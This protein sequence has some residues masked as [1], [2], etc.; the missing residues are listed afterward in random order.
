MTILISLYTFRQRLDAYH[1]LLE[2]MCEKFPQ[3][4]V[5]IDGRRFTIRYREH[6][7][8]FVPAEPDK[9]AG[10]ECDYFFTNS[11]EVAEYLMYR[12]RC[13]EMDDY[14]DVLDILER[15]ENENKE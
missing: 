7:I 8:I 2:A 13:G 10:R 4:K 6:R 14:M 11:L 1:K 5:R 9:I 15:E 12:C 3:S